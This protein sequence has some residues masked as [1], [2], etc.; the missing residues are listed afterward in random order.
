[1]VALGHRD[2]RSRKAALKH[3]DCPPYAARVAGADNVASVRGSARGVAGWSSGIRTREKATRTSIVAAVTGSSAPAKESIVASEVCPPLIQTAMCSPGEPVSVREY[4]ANPFSTLGAVH[5]AA[6]LAADVCP[7]VRQRLVQHPDSPRCVTIRL[8]SDF[9]DDTRA[10]VA[11]YGEVPDEILERLASDPEHSARLDLAGRFTGVPAPALRKLVRDPS[12]DVRA[13]AVGGGC[14][15]DALEQLATD[16]E[17]QVRAR[18]AALEP[19]PRMASGDTIGC[20]A[21]LLEHLSRDPHPEVRAAAAASRHATED[22]LERLCRDDDVS[23]RDNVATNAISP[24]HVLETLAADKRSEVR[25]AAAWNRALPLDA[26]AALASDRS[27]AVRQRIAER[28][29]CPEDVV[30]F[31]SKDTDPKVRK[32]IAARHDLPADIRRATRLR[33]LTH[34]CGGG[35]DGGRPHRPSI[36]WFAH[37]VSKP[38]SRNSVADPPGPNHP[39]GRVHAGPGLQQCCRLGRGRFRIRHKSTPLPIRVSGDAD[40]HGMY[41]RQR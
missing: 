33:Y 32:A 41:G 3:P 8:A 9:D 38:R 18:V 10:A 17:P 2:P 37:P 4:L 12:A 30:A 15:V 19:N 20:P 29:S 1:M 31:L 34:L 5:V 16:P 27:L 40:T 7:S 24:P 35:R 11:R 21:H 22:M 13:V 6:A 26:I 39:S 36:A 25:A 14:D 23:V 28:Y